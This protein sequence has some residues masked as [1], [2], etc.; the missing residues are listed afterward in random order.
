MGNDFGMKTRLTWVMLFCM[1]FATSVL[2]RA[3]YIQLLK[4]PR[5]EMMARRQYQ[6]RSLIR[7]RRGM[8]LD[9]SGE[10]LSV[11]LEAN[12]LAANPAKI[13]N[14]RQLAHLLAKSTSIPFGKILQ[15]LNEKREFTWIK[16]HLSESELRRFKKWRVIDSD[17]DMVEGLWL[18]KES[19]RVYPHGSLAAHV[20]GSVNV[21]S[22]GLEGV[23]LWVNDQ[24]R[25]KVAS[26]SAIKDA[27]GRPTFID[28]EAAKSVQDGEPVT[29]TLDAPLQFEVE[30][31]LKNSVQKANAKGGTVIVMDATSGEILALA[32]EPSFNPN[33]KNSVTDRRR[34]RALTDGYEPGSTF[35]A[36]LLASVLSNGGKLEDEVWAEKGSF[37][38]QGHIISEAKASEKFEWVSAKEMIR[39]S[40]NIAASKF[41]LKLGVDRFLKSIRAFGIGTKSGLGFPGEISGRIPARK[42]WGLLTLANIGFGQGVLV[43]PLQMLRAY[44]AILNGGWLVQPVLLKNDKLDHN[45]QFRIITQRVSQDVT[46]A[47]LSA[48]GEGGTGKKA[49]LPGFRVAGKTGTSQMVDPATGKYSREKYVASFIGFPVGVDPKIVI[50]TSIVEPRGNYYAAETAAPL[51]KEVL[52]SVVNRCSLPVQLSANDQIKTTQAAASVREVLGA[53]ASADTMPRVPDSLI[54]SGLGWVM[55]ELKGFTPRE[56]LK[57]LQGHR[58]HWVVVGNGVVFNQTPEPGKVLIEGDTIRLVLSEP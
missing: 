32:N 44:A 55:P 16:R 1:V 41:A 17:G 24:L 50:F 18:V 8:I 9:R 3:A 35:K 28:A 31:H 25:G 27:L 36:I 33:D 38:I 56:T 47:L 54:P 23:E 5:L 20:I 7:P 39:V 52:G 2:V 21:D 14:K 22:E 49:V 12:S 15:K 10:P 37:K 13:K 42:E 53:N 58:F 30:Q 45:N 6:S 48:T 29:L 26:V 43:T 11:N 34:N 57:L 40:S 4:N 51:F 19:E 46:E